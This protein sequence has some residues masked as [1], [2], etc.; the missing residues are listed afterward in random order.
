MNSR[1]LS[2][3]GAAIGVFL[4]CCAP[5]LAQETEPT[6]D[7]P[8][9]A[10]E[11]QPP[12]PSDPFPERIKLPDGILDGG[13]EWLNTSGPISLKDL[14]GKI[15]LLD[16]WTYCCINCMHVL[17]DLKALEEKYDRQIVV[18][19]VHSAKFDN[20]KESGNIRNA[21]FMM[22]SDT[23]GATACITWTKIPNRVAIRCGL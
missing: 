2:A 21:L 10:D 9:A 8:P 23:F 16:F 11:G 18:I 13:E 20:E 6:T 3:C 15:V 1:M 5:I 14:R 4:L 22:I 12:A 7:S 19:G 17:P